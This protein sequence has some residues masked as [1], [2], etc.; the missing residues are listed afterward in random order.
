V[1]VTVTVTVTVK[2]HVGYSRHVVNQLVGSESRASL[3][4]ECIDQGD[5]AQCTVKRWSL[6]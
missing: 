4:L 2:N 6:S 3:A 5:K 1:T